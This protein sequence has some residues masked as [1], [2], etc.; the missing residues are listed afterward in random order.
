MQDFTGSVFPKAKEKKSSCHQT[1]Q[2]AG[3]ETAAVRLEKQSGPSLKWPVPF[4]SHLRPDIPTVK[5]SVHTPRVRQ[6]KRL[7]TVPGPHTHTQGW[8][9]PTAACD[10]ISKASEKQDNCYCQPSCIHGQQTGAGVCV[11]FCGNLSGY[12]W[13]NRPVPCSKGLFQRDPCIQSVFISKQSIKE[14]GSGSVSWDQI[15]VGQILEGVG[16]LYLL[17]KSSRTNVLTGKFNNTICPLL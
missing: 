6:R 5:I 16:H 4:N 12:G 7:T 14:T 8:P 10:D 15:D 2:A 13:I 9:P 11:C 1:L 17:N 3:A